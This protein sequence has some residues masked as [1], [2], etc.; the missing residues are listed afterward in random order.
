MVSRFDLS[1]QPHVGAYDRNFTEAMMP[2]E[3]DQWVNGFIRWVN[4]TKLGGGPAPTVKT[5]VILEKDWPGYYHFTKL[6]LPP[7]SDFTPEEWK[8][9]ELWPFY[10]VVIDKGERTIQQQRI[11]ILSKV[12]PPEEQHRLESLARHDAI[13]LVHAPTNEKGSDIIWDQNYYAAHCLSLLEAWHSK[14]PETCITH[15]K[16]WQ[17]EYRRTTTP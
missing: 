15:A 17:D 1:N 3:I 6:A 12:M 8:R 7:V 2:N 14:P 9:V 11:E 13:F 5:L 16:E 10:P 4:S